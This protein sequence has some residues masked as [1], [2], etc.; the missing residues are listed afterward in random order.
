VWN[1]INTTKLAIEGPLDSY[2]KE[3]WAKA[4]KSVRDYCADKSNKLVTFT[5]HVGSK[6]VGKVH[7][8]ASSELF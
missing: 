7:T 2:D 3:L 4:I 1:C 6:S 8:L 5:R